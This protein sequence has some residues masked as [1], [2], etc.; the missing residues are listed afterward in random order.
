MGTSLPNGAMGPADASPRPVTDA[1]L[2]QQRSQILLEIRYVG[3]VDDL[4]RNN[5]QLVLGNERSIAF[6]VSGQQLDRL[7]TKLV[8]LLDDRG[9]DNAIRNAAKRQ[10][11]LIEANHL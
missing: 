6:D 10:R 5:D 3:L 1:S 9:L 8:G 7:I 2:T 4:G 11:I